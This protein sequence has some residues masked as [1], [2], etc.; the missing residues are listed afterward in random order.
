MSV[1]D[2]RVWSGTQIAALEAEIGCAV[3]AWSQ[4]WLNRDKAEGDVSILVD[5]DATQNWPGANNWRCYR[6]SNDAWVGA[7]GVDYAHIALCRALTGGQIE[8][9]C[10]DTAGPIATQL[11]DSAEADLAAVLLRLPTHAGTP[12]ADA[13]EQHG[14]LDVVA[15]PGSGCVLVK[16]KLDGRFLS[17]VLS[18]GCV[19]A[20]LRSSRSA[21]PT[22]SPL[23]GSRL[24][25]IDEQT[26]TVQVIAG[27]SEVTI[28]E[29]ESLSKG[30]VI[31]LNQPLDVPLQAVVG[32]T[33]HGLSGYLGIQG[34]NK[35][36]QVTE[37]RNSDNE[38]ETQ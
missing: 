11:M 32:G 2:F 28:G 34:K 35:A 38:G 26:V 5:E 16:W 37:A 17:W 31:R 15:S 7:H 29:L 19:A 30:D 4:R 23:V 12:V 27:R 3:E 33:T 6:S 24:E 1:Y 9:G 25:A 18:G 13:D 36:I 8:L 14:L 21:K 10:N 20:W 22:V